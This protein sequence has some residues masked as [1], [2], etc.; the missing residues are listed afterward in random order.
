MHALTHI[1]TH[2]LTQYIHIHIYTNAHTYIHTNTYIYTYPNIHTLGQYIYTHTMN[3]LKHT[4]T[5]TYVI[6]S[7]NKSEGML[8]Q[9]TGSFLTCCR[10]GAGGPCE[11]WLQQGPVFSGY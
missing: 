8:T 10:G 11:T 6:V 2:T 4:W 1:C 5:H 9:E 3:T 7:P